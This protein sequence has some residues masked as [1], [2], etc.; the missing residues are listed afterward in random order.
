[1]VIA[2]I[3]LIVGTYESLLT[4][5]DV[6]IDVAQVGIVLETSAICQV[7]CRRHFRHHLQME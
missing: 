1:M 2:A 5:Q 6:L 7:A 3:I 4:P